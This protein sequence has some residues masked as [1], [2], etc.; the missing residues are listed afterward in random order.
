M[1][2]PFGKVVVLSLQEFLKMSKKNK[3]KERTFPFRLGLAVTCTIVSSL[4][5]EGPRLDGQ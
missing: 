5:L 2:H 1:F 3:G 4:T